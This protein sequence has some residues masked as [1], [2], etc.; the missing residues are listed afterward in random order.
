MHGVVNIKSNPRKDYEYIGRGSPL[1]NPFVFRNSSHPDAIYRVETREEAICKFEKYLEVK[2]SDCD[3]TFCD[4]LNELIIKNL[5]GET[6]RLGCYCKPQ[7]CHGDVILAFVER[8]RYCLNWFSN[9]KWFT[10]PMVANRITYHSVENVYQAFKFTDSV[11]HRQI[12]E[13]APYSA[14]RLAR[15]LSDHRRKDWDS[16]KLDVMRNALEYKFSC[17]IWRKRLLSTGSNVIAEWNNWGDIFWG[18]DIFTH[19]GENH[20]GRLLMDIRN[21]YR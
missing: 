5:R 6:V 14:K 8:Q 19:E 7:S 20:L 12:A 9:M 16:I 18:I 15:K 10:K 17:P 21:K 3:P 2:V 4:A 1:G 13:S 11:I